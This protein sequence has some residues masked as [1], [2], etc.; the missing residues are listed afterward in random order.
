M[1]YKRQGSSARLVGLIRSISAHLSRIL[2][3][4][5]SIG[6]TSEL[7]VNI[8]NVFNCDERI[9]EVCLVVD[10]IRKTLASIIL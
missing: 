2:G 8:W 9:H 4:T 1:K 5:P 6:E 3:H 7:R 10:L